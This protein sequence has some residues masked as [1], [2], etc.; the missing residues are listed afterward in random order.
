MNGPVESTMQQQE[1]KIAIIISRFRAVQ[2]V[3]EDNRV[4]SDQKAQGFQRKKK[5]NK[6]FAAGDSLTIL[7]CQG[8]L[9]GDAVIRRPQPSSRLTRSATSWRRTLADPYG[10]ALHSWELA[11]AQWGGLRRKTF[12][13]TSSSCQRP[14]KPGRQRGQG[15]CWP[16]WSTPP[17]QTSWSYFRMRRTLPRIRKL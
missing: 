8:R 2:C 16:G 12:A 13:T 5:I 9:I 11:R 4:P 14:P 7:T 1:K 17:M 3:L 6:C 15:S 10:P